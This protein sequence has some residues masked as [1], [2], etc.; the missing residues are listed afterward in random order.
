M[1]D[2]SIK[3]VKRIYTG[4]LG[5]IILVIIAGTASA[6]FV[7]SP[8]FGPAVAT[9]GEQSQIQTNTIAV[10]GTGSVTMPPDEAIVYLGVQTQ[11]VDAISAQEENAAKMERI[12]EALFGA[13]ISKDDMESA[14]Y[15]MYPM[16][17]YSSGTPSITGYTV[18]NQLK[19]KVR[20]VDNVG[21]VIDAAVKAGVNEVQSVSFTLSDKS[22]QDA[23]KEAL[24][25]A[26]TA[27]RSDADSIADALGVRIAL[28]L[29]A[30]TEGGRFTAVPS[31]MMVM[32]EAVVSGSRTP[33]Q[34]GDVSVSATVS[35]M[36]LFE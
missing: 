15:N 33:I 11:S 8:F 31:T 2:K 24:E 21:D 9:S 32:E 30:G 10:T 20:D 1:A 18:S 19:V 23:R 5:L 12:I 28:P 22:Q 16:R 27:A 13:G 26:V 7:Q 4:L 35:V 3:N 17:D 14:N 36:Y 6:A 25:N 34:P 29:Q